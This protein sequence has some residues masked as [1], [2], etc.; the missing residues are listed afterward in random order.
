MQ[1]DLSTLMDV[2]LRMDAVQHMTSKATQ[3]SHSASP[4]IQHESFTCISFSNFNR[5]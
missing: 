4:S 1:S 5:N 3:A 2:R